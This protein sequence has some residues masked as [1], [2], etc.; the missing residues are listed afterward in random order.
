MLLTYSLSRVVPVAIVFASTP[1][2]VGLIGTAQY[3]LYTTITALVLIAESFGVGWL[4]QSAL[5]GTGDPYQAM[6]LLPRWSMASAVNGPAVLVAVL[7]FLLSGALGAGG[8]PAVLAT[9][10]ALCCATGFYMLRMTRAQRDMRVRR[11]VVIEWVRAAV[12]LLA[13]IAVH[14][15]LLEGAAAALAGMAIGSLA[16]A[17]VAGRGPQQA[18]RSRSSANALLKE[19]WSYGWPMSLWLAASSGL[20]YVDRLLLSVWLGPETAGHYGAVS[21]IVI[22]G[23]IF[24]ATPVGMAVHPLI[25]SAWN[26]GRPDLAVRTLAAYQR[27]LGLLVVAATVA[28]VAAGPWLIP[29][30][31]GVRAPSTAVLMLLGLGSAVWQYSLLT[32]KRLELAGRSFAVLS[33]MGAS[34][35]VTVVVD[36]ALIPLTGPLGAAIGMAAGA[37]AYH[38]GCLHLGRKAIAEELQRGG[39]VSSSVS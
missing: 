27:I 11:V 13:I 3:G 5:R 7:L 6:H 25:M 2:L 31:V 38:A 33:L 17:L 20:L 37:A 15:T 18:P 4:R 19:Y 21:D 35:L 16:G 28:L 24:I 39:P 36:V 26:R 34:T 23:Y 29:I 10:T 9:A 30:V 12:G 8:D 1:I 22:R 14:A 32:Q